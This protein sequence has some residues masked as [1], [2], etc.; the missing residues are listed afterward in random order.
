MA[1]FSLT[2]IAAS[3]VS[4]YVIRR[5]YWEA[6]TGARRRAFAK[7][8]GCLPPR[9]RLNR[10]FP[11]FI[12]HFGL[13]F[14]LSNLGALKAHVVLEQQSDDLKD[15]GTHT[16]DNQEIGRN[17]FLT[18]DPENVK[19][20][21][22][23]NFDT[24]SLGQERID[25]LS[26]FL[27]HGIFTN[28][29][30]AW[31]HSREMLRPCFERSAVADVSIF[32]K[33]TER[34]IALLPTDGSDVDLQPLFHELTLDVA[35]EF[36]FGRSTDSLDRENDRKE[37]QEFIEALEY[38]G[39]PLSSDNVQKYGY[40]GLFLR[41]RKRNRS[42]R[43]IQ[44]FTDKVIDEELRLKEETKD[45]QDNRYIFLDEIVT[46]TQDRTVI[47]SELLNI[48]LA[49]R[50]TTASLLSN[51]LWELPRHPSILARLRAEITTTIIGET[52]NGNEDHPPSYQQLKEM[53]YLRAII[54]ESQR[55]Y[56]IVPANSRQALHDTVIPNGGGGRAGSPILVPK[57]S[58]VVYHTYSMHRRPSIFG[59]DAHEFNPDRWLDP[60]FRPGWAYIPF[61]GG[62]RVC[63][64]QNFALTEAMF[65]IVRLVQK[66]EF[67]RKDFE[68][69]R[70]K[71]TV[72]CT[73]LGGCK[74]GLGKRERGRRM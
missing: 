39:D 54:N 49:G 71:L 41:D 66:F 5:I 63:I 30:K 69:W 17:F 22:A 42:I 9:Q 59:P 33:H 2:N 61:S 34:L 67:E 56:P 58:Y 25:Y 46:A 73:G 11:D 13:D 48:L 47:R 50:D 29:G 28:E 74:V 72:T 4:L 14:T 1:I 38:C 6:T 10:I 53:K 45:S 20:M 7:Q 60:G 36:L 27:G 68:E 62:P 55:L 44:D 18:D 21:L 16:I 40:L 26:S 43:L 51:V 15:A 3:L 23:T 12:P 64:G 37:V 70:E 31:K 57:G 65:V 8:H 35:T 19:S 52:E 24:W 32:A